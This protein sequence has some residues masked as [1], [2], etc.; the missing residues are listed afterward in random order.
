ML[1]FT[2]TNGKG[3]STDDSVRNVAQAMARRYIAAS[4]NIAWDN[5]DT[6][7]EDDMAAVH[8]YMAH[9]A[10]AAYYAHTGG[11]VWVSYTLHDTMA[12]Y[13]LLVIAGDD[14]LEVSI[15]SGAARENVHAAEDAA[16]ARYAECGADHGS[17]VLTLGV[18]DDDKPCARDA[19]AERA[20]DEFDKASRE[21]CK[22]TG[23]EYTGPNED[24]CAMLGA[25]DADLRAWIDDSEHRIG[26]SVAAW[27]EATESY[28]DA[29]HAELF[30]DEL[31]TGI[32]LENF[33]SLIARNACEPMVD[34]CHSH[35]FCD[36]NVVMANACEQDETAPVT[37]DEV[38][39]MMRAWA[40]AAPMLGKAVLS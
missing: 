39:E 24:D 13:V 34:V 30:V 6:T 33:V 21:W 26:M 29:R 9:G 5:P 11:N 27:R 22:R 32:G 25:S 10:R 18:V 20:I 1:Q 31:R 35:D 15:T 19:L 37:D 38:A 4:L 3:F 23:A 2:T 14:S 12:G 40:A 7:A 36:A 8:A 28:I 17:V 16:T